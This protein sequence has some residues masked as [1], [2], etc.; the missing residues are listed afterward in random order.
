MLDQLL[1]NLGFLGL[2][3]ALVALFCLLEV[4]LRNLTNR[5]AARRA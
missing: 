5:F 3:V 4:V 1:N 2:G